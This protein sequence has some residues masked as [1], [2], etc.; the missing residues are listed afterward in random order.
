[1]QLPTITNNLT[2]L[3]AVVKGLEAMARGWQGILYSDSKVTW[4]RL[5]TSSKFNNIPS[6]LSKKCLALRRNKL[7]TPILC[8]GHPKPADL[9][10]GYDHRG[11][12][13]FTHNVWCDKRCTELAKRFKERNNVSL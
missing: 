7:W 9:E 5:T 1:M 13:V 2:E 4:W 11:L 6:E 10:V 12:P 3:L 8:G